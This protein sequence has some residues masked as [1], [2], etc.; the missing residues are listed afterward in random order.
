MQKQP[1]VFPTRKAAELGEA[2]RPGI[3]SRPTGLPSLFRYPEGGHVGVHMCNDGM[4][5]K[6]IVKDDGIG[7]SPSLPGSRVPYS[8]EVSR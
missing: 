3:Q 7:M 6:V 1:T 8:T 5:I 4:Y 2:D